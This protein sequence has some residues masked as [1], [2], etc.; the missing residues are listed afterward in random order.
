MCLQSTTIK[1]QL[2]HSAAQVCLLAC[3]A[4]A[5][6][7]FGPLELRRRQ[8]AIRLSR[9]NSATAA[10]AAAANDGDDVQ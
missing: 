4:V 1:Q 3:A 6:S 7:T 8:L 5:S 9:Y 2:E 10:A